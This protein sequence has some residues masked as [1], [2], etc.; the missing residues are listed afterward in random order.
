MLVRRPGDDPRRRLSR[1]AESM[2]KI[3]I[4][5]F[6]VESGT[7][8]LQAMHALEESH[9]KVLFVVDRE[10]HLIGSL[11]D[12]DIR[13]WILGGGSLQGEIRHVCNPSPHKVGK[14]HK[15]SLVKRQMV[16]SGIEGIP[17]VDDQDRI[18]DILFWKTL[19]QEEVQPHIHSRIESSVVIM[20][21]GQGSRL[22]P[23]TSILPKP[24]I[25]VGGKAILEIIIDRFGAHGCSDFLVSVHH[26][27]KIIKSYFE[28]LAPSY[29]VE[30]VDEPRPLGTAGALE[31]LKG[32]LRSP[33]FV[34]NCDIL[35]EADY[36]EIMAHHVERGHALTVV[37]SL[38][39]YIIPYGI[40]T[41]GEG[42]SLSDIEEKPE[43]GYLVNTG[44]YVLD[45]R[46]L[47]LIHPDESIHMTDLIARTRT[48]G[49]GVGVFPIGE[50]C[51]FD[52][53]EWAEYRKT[54]QQFQGAAA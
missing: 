42:G 36:G 30:F 15:K 6:L 45:P 54:I 33:F 14:G 8:I 28:E 29:S 53:G 22:A 11:T 2:I 35:V 4:A 25:P 10:R 34:T 20:A 51:W 38:K 40:C 41:V 9:E 46:V 7:S 16:E 17:V 27:A 43:F 23:F 12:G 52:T 47:E 18:V 24:L 49:L 32:R 3:D 5:P 13:R 26:K 19:F 1:K 31:Q 21:G 50:N 44:M 37:A 39:R 48:A